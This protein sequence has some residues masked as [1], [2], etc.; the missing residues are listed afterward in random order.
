MNRQNQFILTFVLFALTSTSLFAQADNDTTKTDIDEWQV[1]KTEI[2]K[3]PFE[4]S[5]QFTI[6]FIDYTDD[7]WCY[8]LPGSKLISPYGG[9]RHHAGTDLKTKP[10]DTIY[11]IFPGEVI[12][13]GVHYGYGNCVIIRHANG[14]ETLYSHNSKNLVKVGQWV[15][16]GQAI[17]L[18]GRTGRATTEH[19]HL[20]TRVKGKAF[21]SSKIFDHANHTIRR[22]KLV[23]TQSGGKINIVT[24]TK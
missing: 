15:K 24:G 18:T 1:L 4:K 7:Q 3:D 22:V 14:L 16:C 23:A 13:S 20:E 21:D 9:A 2:K 5:N 8:P 10:N 17:A 12:L 11:A 19:L 6:N